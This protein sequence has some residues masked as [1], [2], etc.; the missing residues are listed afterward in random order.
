M[1]S[2]VDEFDL[3]PHFRFNEACIGAQWIAKENR[4]EVRFKNVKTGFESSRSTT[5]FVSAV[6]GISEPRKVVFPGMETF[7]GEIFHTARWNHK[8]DYAGKRVAIIG[9]GC[10]AAQVIPAVQP[11]VKHVTQSVCL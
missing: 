6:G 3:R 1:E 9:N 4:W 5:I 10:S 7:K 8:Y 2:T 11:K